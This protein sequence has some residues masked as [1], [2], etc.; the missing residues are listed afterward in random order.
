MQV[1]EQVLDV[2]GSIRLVRR[3][4]RP[5]AVLVM[6]G[7][8]AGSLFDVIAV[9]SYHATALV[10]LPAPVGGTTTGSSP[11]SVTTDAKVATS[12]A[13]LAPAGHK[14]DPALSLAAVQRSVTASKNA[15]GVL[16][17]TATAPTRH[18]AMDLAN[19]VANQ[20]VVFLTTSGS[21]AESNVVA[22]L[23]AQKK[24]LAGQVADVQHELVAANQRLTADTSTPAARQQDAA[25]VTSLTSQE[26]SLTLQ[27]N[28]LKSQISQATLDG[29]ATDQGTEVIQRA[30]TATPASAA[31]LA[32]PVVL[33]AIGGALLGSIIVL[34]WHRKDPRLRTRDALAATL[35]VPVLAS[36]E[37]APCRSPEEWSA[38]FETYE[39]SALER[40]RARTALR[41]AGLATDPTSRLA[42]LTL[43]GDA[44]AVML[45]ARLAV[46]AAASGLKTTFGVVADGDH[47]ATLRAVCRHYA[48]ER[49]APRLGLRMGNGGSPS[50]RAAPELAITATVVDPS[51]PQPAP[52]AQPPTASML[53]V[54][55]GFA[56]AEQLAA[57]AVAAADRGEPLS[58]VLV[59]NPT[60]ADHSVGRFVDTSV[61]ESPA[62]DERGTNGTKPKVSP[63]PVR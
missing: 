50:R 1:S 15:A 4:W 2:K 54:S 31:A 23:R 9:P 8:V 56:S 26:S 55:A 22:G 46:A 36:L 6:T 41:E 20:V 39:P 18:R 61:R 19:A 28:S 24:Q 37:V 10:L 27:L 60:P 21:A 42:V 47:A 49:R 33:G 17:V 35:G 30:T 16:D 13:V 29:I 58:G 34:A 11:R 52:T 5:V 38:F 45:T 32:L 12:A 44:P 53:S 7:I 48:S 3:F 43:A 62:A 57:V 59:A 14:V 63:G 40:W 25:L 51:R